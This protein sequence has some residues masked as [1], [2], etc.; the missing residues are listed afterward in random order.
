[1]NV[2]Y[3]D[4]DHWEDKFQNLV[5]FTMKSFKKLVRNIASYIPFSSFRSSCDRFTKGK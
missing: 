3:C 5:K 2:I 1:M 4:E